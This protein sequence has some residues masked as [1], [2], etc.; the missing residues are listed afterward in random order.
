MAKTKQTRNGKGFEYA[1]LTAIENAC[2][3]KGVQ[4]VKRE[5]T[6]LSAAQ[7]CF[8]SLDAQEQA[9]YNLAA[10][11]P[12]PFLMACEPN[13][14]D[15]KDPGTLSIGLQNDSEG[16]SGD[17]RDV[18]LRRSNPK[19]TL[20]D[21]ECGISCKHNH[22]ATKHPRINF[23]PKT[24]KDLFRTSW[25]PS[26]SMHQDYFDA[27]KQVYELCKQGIEQK[28]LWEDVF[29]DPEQAT[30]VYKPINLGLMKSIDALKTNEQF[31]REFFTY[32]MGTND[33]YKIIMHD[34]EKLTRVTVFNFSKTLGA[35]SKTI[36]K[37]NF[38]LNALPVP[39]RI[40]SVA[41]VSDSTFH[42]NFD[43]GWAFSFRLHN[44]DSTMKVS[45]LKYDIRLLGVPL[46][47]SNLIFPW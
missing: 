10:E 33:F 8:K 45:G 46:C 5:S 4:I 13:L 15:A 43:E 26:F 14:N 40:I 25:A 42:V 9:Q 44:A 11:A 30:Y 32:C 24:K 2:N 17:V 22:D 19:K 35:P 37:G 18:L 20:I 29:T 7:S 1:C 34:K 3:E 6:A 12:I 31:V 41:Y 16:Q 36:K 38:K 47:T 39:T 23:C 28:K 21:W 27:C